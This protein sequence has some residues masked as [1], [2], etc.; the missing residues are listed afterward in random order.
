MRFYALRLKGKPL[1]MSL[2]LTRRDAEEARFCHAHYGSDQ[3][4]VLPVRVAWL[5]LWFWK[6][7]RWFRRM[8]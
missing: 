4:E 8:R 7:A 2:F 1:P 5:T 6:V 3:L